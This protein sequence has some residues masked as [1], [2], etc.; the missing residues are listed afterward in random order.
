MAQSIEKCPVSEM[1]GVRSGRHMN[2]MSVSQTF[3]VRWFDERT[4]STAE[5]VAQFAA[6]SS[7]QRPVRLPLSSLGALGPA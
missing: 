6:Q 2:G 3:R 4:R 1:T 5:R 7:K